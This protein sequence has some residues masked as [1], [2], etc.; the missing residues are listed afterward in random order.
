MRYFLTENGGPERQVPK[1]VWI[2]AERSAGFR[3][4]GP[5]R[6][7]PATGGFGATI[8]GSWPSEISGRIENFS[9]PEDEYE[10]KDNS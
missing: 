3:P 4:K 1:E 6:G 5:D 7:Q 9:N 10:P 2:N 8:Q